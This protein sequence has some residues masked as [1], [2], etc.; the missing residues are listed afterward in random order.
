MAEKATTRS[1]IKIT[2]DAVKKILAGVA[3]TQ[4]GILRRVNGV[5]RNL[6]LSGDTIKPNSANI[7]LKR[8]LTAELPSLVVDNAYKSR[9]DTY[10]RNF[11][12][13]KP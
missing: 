8:Q 12:R 10:L 5:L 9:V 4:K 6:E 2:E 3:T 1:I 11:D 7:K 13:I